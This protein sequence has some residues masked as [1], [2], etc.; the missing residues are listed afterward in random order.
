M[1]PKSLVATA[2]WSVSEF[3]LLVAV[4]QVLEVEHRASCRVGRYSST[5]LQLLPPCLTL[6]CC[7]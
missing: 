3:T 1:I 7:Y 4:F 5:E 2:L 6:A